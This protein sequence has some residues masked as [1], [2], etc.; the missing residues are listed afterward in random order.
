MSEG[1]LEDIIGHFASTH[2]LS[3]CFLGRGSGGRAPT[4][5]A[6]NIASLILKVNADDDDDDDH[7]RTPK[8]RRLAREVMQRHGKDIPV[9]EIPSVLGSFCGAHITED[10]WTLV[11]SSVVARRAAIAGKAV[12][13]RLAASASS[14]VMP[15]GVVVEAPTTATAPSAIVAGAVVAEWAG[16]GAGELQLALARKGEELNH[17]KAE[18]KR[19]RDQ[20]DY[21]AHRG[22]KLQHALL[23]ERCQTMALVAKLNFRPGLKCISCFGGYS[24]ALRRNIGNAS[25]A[26]T[27]KMV[28]GSEEQGGLH[29]K[30]VSGATTK[31]NQHTV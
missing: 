5:S 22:A 12:R 17:M 30:K 25:A 7:S 2:A 26:V 8:R 13:P 31:A 24:L 11:C 1:V 10:D 16:M 18:L 6:F 14:T 23:D 19:V 21:H 27:A 20:R 15:S 3:S 28:A 9:D 29:D 4:A